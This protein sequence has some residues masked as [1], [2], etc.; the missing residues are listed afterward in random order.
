MMQLRVTALQL[1]ITL[2]YTGAQSRSVSVSCQLVYV[3][4]AAAALPAIVSC[5]EVPAVGDVTP[6]MAQ[7][8][9]A[10]KALTRLGNAVSQFV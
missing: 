1:I 6:E 10:L 8:L 2:Q 3:R 5:S 7:L 9:Q 4:T